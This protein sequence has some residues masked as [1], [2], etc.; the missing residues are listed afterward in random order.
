MR[1]ADTIVDSRR[2]VLVWEPGQKVPI[3]AFPSR[4]WS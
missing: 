4:R 2:A 1:G 3:Y